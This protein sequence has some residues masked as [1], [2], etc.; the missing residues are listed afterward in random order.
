MVF[1]VFL[2]DPLRFA[3]RDVCRS[4]TRGQQVA[5]LAMGYELLFFCHGYGYNRRTTV[6]RSFSL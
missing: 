6:Q 4:Y 1:S 5:A 2:K 3:C